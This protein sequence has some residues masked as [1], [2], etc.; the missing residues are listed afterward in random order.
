MKA[1]VFENKIIQVS[2]E[3]EVSEGFR[4]LDLPEQDN[5]GDYYIYNQT[6]GLV[7]A[8]ADNRNTLVYKTAD[9]SEHVVDYLGDIKDGFTTLEPNE[10]DVWNVDKWNR[11][12]N[13]FVLG[14]TEN[15][16]LQL[17]QAVLSTCK[18]NQ[19]YSIESMRT[20]STNSK[21][22]LHSIAVKLNKWETAQNNH[23]IG[24]L[25]QVTAG[26]LDV[27]TIVFETEMT[28]FIEDDW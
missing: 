1:L 20:H 24:L 23:F 16:K 15:L 10:Y 3:F 27:D 18:Y 8:I 26:T 13:L 25:T 2:E 17:Y 9:K 12:D 11:D 4:W 21:S 14:T 6:S 28:L 22:L 7:E 19:F 5:E